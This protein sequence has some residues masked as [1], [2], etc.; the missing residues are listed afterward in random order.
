M[1]SAV[2]IVILGVC[3]IK[4]EVCQLPAETGPCKAYMPMYFHNSATGQCEEFIYGGCKGNDNKF[5][6]EEECREACPWLTRSLTTATEDVCQLPAVTGDCKGA[7]PMYFYSSESG[8]C[9]KFI[10]GGC[11]GNG[12]KF[13]TVEECQSACP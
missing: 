11:G 3:A 7:F 9:E 4:A 2:L 8:Q 10:Y 6:S 13:N 12:N 5:L 1:F